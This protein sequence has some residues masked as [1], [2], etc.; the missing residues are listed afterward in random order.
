MCLPIIV[1]LVIGTIEACSMVFLKQSLAIAAYEGAR[2]AI[3][4]GA[5]K[6]QV[7]AA[8]NR[9]WPIARSKAAR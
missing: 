2:T 4:P 9:S 8:C 6:A 5:T 1:L 3:I 7:E